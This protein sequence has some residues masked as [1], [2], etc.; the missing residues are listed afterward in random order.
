MRL[1]ITLIAVFSVV[2]CCVASN[3]TTY[4]VLSCGLSCVNSVALGGRCGVADLD[5]QCRSQKFKDSTMK[6][7][8]ADCTVHETFTFLNATAVACKFPAESR[9]EVLKEVVLGCGIAS[10]II[11]LIRLILRY[12]AQGNY[13]AD[14]WLTLIAL[15]PYFFMFYATLKITMEGLGKHLWNVQENAVEQILLWSFY[16]RV[17]V[18]KK[19]QLIVKLTMVC[20][21]VFT[22]SIMCASL[23]ECIPVSVAWQVSLKGGHCL[24]YS[25]ASWAYGSLTVAIDIIT[26]V[27]PIMQIWAL[28][29]SLQK[30]ISVCFVFTLG[31][32][33]CV[34][35][36]IRLDSLHQ[37]GR[38]S[39]PTWTNV[40]CT[41]WSAI[42]LGVGLVCASI[43]AI[44]SGIRIIYTRHLGH[45][46]STHPS[47]GSRLSWKRRGDAIEIHRMSSRSRS[48]VV[49]GEPT[50]PVKAPYNKMDAALERREDKVGDE[51]LRGI[52]RTTSVTVQYS[53]RLYEILLGMYNENG[54][55]LVAAQVTGCCCPQ[56]V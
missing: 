45:T 26:L 56:N 46:Q 52:E 55:E 54:S 18:N 11:V 9:Q 24:N 27:L 49:G 37:F 10:T 14:D 20:N 4:N 22:I 3:A 23:F 48:S 38:T 31:A 50:F 25:A 39:D 16:L 51:H 30:K 21:I 15:F 34:A 40:P 43:P 28:Q 12:M 6:C 36:M 32:F 13:G 19:F 5:C 33:V 1:F 44:Y 2:T 35:S 53:P 42:E 17:F 29:M 7:V 47:Y 8:L 41:I